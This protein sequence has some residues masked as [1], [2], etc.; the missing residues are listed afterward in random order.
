MLP[1][2]MAINP[3]YFPV[4]IVPVLLLCLSRSTLQVALPLR[5][6]TR[7]FTSCCNIS[8]TKDTLTRY[9][10]RHSIHNYHSFSLLTFRLIWGSSSSLAFTHARIHVNF[11][12]HT[13]HRSS[14][15]PNPP[16]DDSLSLHHLRIQGGY[17]LTSSS[18][19]FF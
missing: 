16:T 11:T 2:T 13:M 14:P 3:Y 19:F 1:Y 4:V 18:V 10:P 12:S 17:L 6:H 15:L 8:S 7:L 9:R 5:Y